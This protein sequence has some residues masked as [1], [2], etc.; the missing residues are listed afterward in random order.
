MPRELCMSVVCDLP[1]KIVEATLPDG[2]SVIFGCCP[3][4]GFTPKL[5][6]AGERRP[7]K[8]QWL[9]PGHDVSAEEGENQLDLPE[10]SARFEVHK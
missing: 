2:S 8:G 9:L 6:I 7:V 1:P 3:L 10:V 5:L 4:C